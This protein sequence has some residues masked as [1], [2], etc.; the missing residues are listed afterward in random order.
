MPATRGGA[1][2]HYRILLG[3]AAGMALL[4]SV[5]HSVVAYS[6]L[7]HR[8][9]V[10]AIPITLQLGEATRLLDGSSDWNDCA[11]AG[12][13]A[14]NSIL[15]RTGVWFSPVLDSPHAP[16]EDDG[17]NH[18]FFADNIFGTPFGTQVLAVTSSFFNI[19]DGVDEAT[20]S[21]IV[22]NNTKRFNCYRGSRRLGPEPE[23]SNI[24]D[25]R[26]V[27]THEFGHALGLDHPDGDGQD[28]KALMNGVIGDIDVLQPDDIRGV[29]TLYGI[30][31][32]GIQF[33]PRDEQFLF[34]LR[35]GDEYQHTLGRKQ[36]SPSFVDTEG[37]AVWYPEFLRYTVSG[38]SATEATDRVFLQIQGQGI[39][40]ECGELPNDVIE[41][42]PRDVSLTFLRDL[43]ELYRTVLGRGLNFGFVDLEGKAVW[44]GEYLRY[45]VNGCDHQAA[46]SN[47]LS[48]IR[49]GGIPPVCTIADNDAVTL[50]GALE[51]G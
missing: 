24:N 41:F 11:T 20:E 28:I 1:V 48:Q 26:R 12:L 21:D 6:F 10:G 30:S 31:I 14:W 39:Q 25:L 19:Q 16:A 43:S 9:P 23:R 8:W 38:C 27:A 40:P 7:G 45:R 2:M 13:D 17:H 5:G 4:G 42:P 22:F 37:S 32:T 3:L 18:V 49:G 15:G 50:H 44:L 36:N 29:L 46:V 47:V 33:P 34:F 35:L 51:R